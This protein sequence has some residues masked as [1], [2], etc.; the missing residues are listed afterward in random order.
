MNW[1]YIAR[2]EMHPLRLRI[3]EHL[4]LGEPGAVASP[5]ELSKELD[6]PLGNVS[7]HVG[8]LHEQGLLELVKT[9]PRRGAVEHFY[10]ATP[11]ASGRGG[12]S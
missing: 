11:I 6:A 8:K 2:K 12:H 1:E 3:L 10:G 7:Y 5:N 4:L 9:E